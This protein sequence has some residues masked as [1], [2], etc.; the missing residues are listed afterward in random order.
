MS[1]SV[2]I[3]G[4][5]RVRKLFN[6]VPNTPVKIV[7]EF[8]PG[9]T[10]KTISRELTRLLRYEPGYTAIFVICGICSITRKRRDGRILLRS[11]NVESSVNRVIDDF[12]S[13]HADAR[14]FTRVPVIICPVTGID[15]MKYSS[16]DWHSY[17]DQPILDKIVN[18]SNL[19]IRGINRLYGYTTPDISSKVHRCSGHGGN[20]RSH[21]GHLW[22]GCHPSYTLRAW[23]E[24]KILDYYIKFIETP[25]NQ[26]YPYY[27]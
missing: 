14:E 24:E 26:V 18:K 23:W 12:Y 20:Y 10:V 8:F 16:Y 11:Y 2:L 19:Q 4:D 21:Y 22:D 15:L 7:C 9:A 13:L 25:I 17:R 5:S 3:I 27:K 1:R 6:Y